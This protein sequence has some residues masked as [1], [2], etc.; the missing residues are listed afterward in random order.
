M[1]AAC[2]I[3]A[4]PSANHTTVI[5]EYNK[6]FDADRVK[7]IIRLIAFVFTAAP[8]PQQEWRTHLPAFQFD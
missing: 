3:R 1:Q 4:S 6:P 8:Q 7:M 2:E 5:N